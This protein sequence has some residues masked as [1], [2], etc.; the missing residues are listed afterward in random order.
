MSGRAGACL[1][2]SFRGAA[3]ASTGS[4]T[5]A[6]KARARRKIIEG[7]RPGDDRSSLTHDDRLGQP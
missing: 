6:E 4:Q 3:W 2:G 1:A 5:Q 7:D